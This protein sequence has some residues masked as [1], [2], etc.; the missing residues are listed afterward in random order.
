MDP[1]ESI[2]LAVRLPPQRKL[3]LH[4]EPAA[5]EVQTARN[6]AYVVAVPVEILVGRTLKEDSIGGVRGLATLNRSPNEVVA[7]EHGSVATRLEGDTWRTDG[8]GLVAYVIA[9]KSERGGWRGTGKPT[10]PK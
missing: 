8:P 5:T 10:S 4:G 2:P 1:F 7:L 3:D 9:E 6:R